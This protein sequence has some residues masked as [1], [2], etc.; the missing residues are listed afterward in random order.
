MIFAGMCFPFGEK[1]A[2]MSTHWSIFISDDMGILDVHNQLLTVGQCFHVHKW[3]IEPV[4]SLT[5]RGD[6]PDNITINAGH[7]ANESS[8]Y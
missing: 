5:M 4:T 6:T 3:Q 2:S 7:T 1:G 8:L